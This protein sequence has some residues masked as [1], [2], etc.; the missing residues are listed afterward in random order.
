MLVDGLNGH[1]IPA[2]GGL[3]IATPTVLPTGCHLGRVL[4]VSDMLTAGPPYPQ[5]MHPGIS[6]SCAVAVPFRPEFGTGPASLLTFGQ[7]Q[8]QVGG[9]GVSF[10][11]RKC[12][13]CEGEH[14]E[15]ASEYSCRG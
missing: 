7:W 3:S 6:W 15:S 13:A 11:L 1:S 14:G 4:P 5:G 9:V 8:G 10:L 12:A 2:Y